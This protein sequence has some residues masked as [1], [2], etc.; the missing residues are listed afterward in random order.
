MKQPQFA[1]IVSRFNETVTDG[2][3][4]GAM[5]TFQ[6]HGYG[7]EQ[8]DTVYAP[9]AF[10]IPIIA[11]RLTE[12]GKYTGVVCL[13][14]VIKGETAHFEYISEACSQGIM[15]VMLETNIPVAF[16]VLTTYNRAQAVA[17]SRNDSHNKGRE[18]ALACLETCDVLESV[19]CREVCEVS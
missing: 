16:G 8:V 17:R 5:E 12:T 11:K 15:R 6:E 10:E 19:Q 14:C 13:G 2:L 4:H 3:H 7:K 18:A 1:I 9:G